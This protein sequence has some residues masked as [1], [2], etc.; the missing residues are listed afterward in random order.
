MS[1]VTFETQR[2]ALAD[3]VAIPVTPF[4][5]DGT[6]DQSAHR[7][8]LRRLLDGGITTLTPNGNTGEF[9]ALTPEERRLVTEL[10][11]DEVGDRAVILVGVGHDVPTAIA[12]AEHAREIG[13]QMVMVHQPVHPYVS[14]DGWVDYHRAIAEAVPELGVVPYIRN[15]QLT[16]VRLAE[17]ADTCPNVIGVKYAVPDAARFAAFARDAGLERFVWVAGLAEPYAPS[18]FSAGATGFTSGLVNVSPAVS[19]N[20]IEALRSGDFPAA[21]KVWEQIRRFEELR[22]ANG[23][24]NNVTVVKEA[25]ASLGLCRRDVRAP[26]RHL[27]EDERAEVAAIAAGW[28]M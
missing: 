16:G 1:S 3:V 17:L 22:A 11:M 26:S 24:A 13:A 7:A 28:S 20:M 4:A 15:A 9:Y 18:Y 2:A 14:Q 10:T 12:S 19:L 6:V 21:M 27:P 5:E 23:S 25:L 8:L